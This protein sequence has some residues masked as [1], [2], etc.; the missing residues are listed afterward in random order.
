M[1]L[2]DYTLEELKDFF[3]K[4]GIEAFR[5][6]QVFN[7]IYLGYSINEISNLPIYIRKFLNER[8]T[9]GIPEIVKSL[10]SKDGTE[11]FLLKYNDDDMVEA[12]LMKY[13]YGNTICISSQIGCRMGCKFCASGAFGLN[14]NLTSGEMIGEILSVKKHTF[15]NINKVVIMGSG[16]P[17]DNYDNVLKFIDISNKEYSLKLS[18]RNITLSTC[19]IVPKIYELADKNLSINLAISLHATCD[20]E[21]IKIMKIANSY[22]IDEILKAAKYYFNKTKRRV[23]FEYALIHLVN[24][25]KEDANRLSNLLKDINCHVNIIPINKVSHVSFERPDIRR[26][27]DFINILTKNG[28]NATKRRELGKDIEAS[29]GQLKNSHFSKL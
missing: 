25:S 21:R 22:T 12:A 16:E 10:K 20:E 28:V 15:E 3:K 27:N 9:L 17:L 4:E 2:L 11:K 19:G 7:G 18:K 24:D 13:S 23:T 26:I 8:F 1:N 5:A 29:C 6:E 14:R